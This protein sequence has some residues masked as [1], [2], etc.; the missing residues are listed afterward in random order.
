MSMAKRFYRFVGLL[1]VL[2]ALD[3][4]FVV[5]AEGSLLSHTAGCRGQHARCA[6][7][8]HRADPADV[9]VARDRFGV[10]SDEAFSGRERTAFYL[11][12]QRPF[13]VP[14]NRLHKYL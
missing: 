13:P 14:L 4:S 3:V 1:V 5:R 12:D 8:R 6:Q 10:N 2:L 11:V 7:K 9:P